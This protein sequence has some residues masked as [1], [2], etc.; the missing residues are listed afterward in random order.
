MTVTDSLAI[1]ICRVI[2]IFFM[3][4]VHVNPGK[5]NWTGDVS[6]N[7]IQ[8][9]YI[10]GDVLGIASVPALSVLGGFLA[11][12][13]YSRRGSWWLYIKERWQSLILPLI[14]WNAIIIV[15]SLLIFFLTRAQTSITR[16]LMPFNQLTP[17]IIIDRLTGYYY[18][19][20]T[21]ALN[22]LRDIFIC[23]VL[24][25]LLIK[26]IKKFGV[27]I[28]GIIWFAG[29]TIGFLPIIIR[30]NIL[31]FF[32]AGVYFGLHNKN[33]TPSLECTF[34]LFAALFLAFLLVILIPTFWSSYSKNLSNTAFQ[35]IIVC[36]FLIGTV[37]L[38]KSR[39][40]KLIARL[41]PFA[42]LMFLSHATIMLVLWGIWQIFFGADLTWPYS[43]FFITAP[44]ATLIV[45]IILHK[46]LANLPHSI[47][48]IFNGKVISRSNNYK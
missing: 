8:I 13:A 31:I 20:A 32:T 3:T 36:C 21:T 12:A 14:T 26:F 7:L 45:V 4:Y 17:L 27:A 23:S 29:L 35:L 24:L 10:L 18:G 38:S 9:G 34:K 48:R 22:F 47:Q 16:H 30:P 6:E 39:I 46:V 44:F 43:V 33:L 5:A 15:L 41:E 28:I 37:A 42:Y 11:V 2:C 25:P 1:K 40:G 19:S